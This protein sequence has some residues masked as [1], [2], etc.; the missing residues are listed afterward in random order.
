LY[1]RV[2][3]KYYEKKNLS[4]KVEEPFP[5]TLKNEGTLLALMVP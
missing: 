5:L 1:A 3:K 2:Q 4:V